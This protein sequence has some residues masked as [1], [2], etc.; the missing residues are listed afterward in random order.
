M[1]ID[2]DVIVI[3]AGGGGPV[4]AKELGELGIDVL[5]LEAG[6]WYGNKKWPE[7][8]KNR[9]EAKESSN[10]NDLDGALYRKQL[11]RLEDDMNDLVTGKFRWG[12]ADRRRT[13]WYRNIPDPALLWQSA[14]IGGST[15]HYYANS[16]RAFPH[17]IDNEWPIR[18]KELVPYYEKVEKTLPVE[19]APTTSKEALFYYGAEKAGFSLN[20]TLDATSPGY[21]PQPNAILPPNEH[22][23]DP[24]YSLEELS[25]M[26]G[27]T[28]SGHCGQ[29][30]P[31]GP[32]LEK[33]AKRSTNVSYVPLAMKTGNV[34]FRPNTFVTKVVTEHG[35]KRGQ[36]AA[37]VQIR[38]T[39][40]GE[41]EELRAKVIVMAAGCIETPRLWLN[42]VLPHND[43]VGRG[44]TTHYM[45]TVTGTFDE[46]TLMEILGSPSVNPFVGHT[47]GARLDYPGLGMIENLGESPGL[48]AMQLFGFSQYGY[49]SLRGSDSSLWEQRGRLVGSELEEAMDGYRKSLT[50]LI[51]TD[52][53][54]D[55]QNRV[56]LDSNIK[57]EHGPVPF[58]HYTP[59]E[60]SIKRREELVK[61]ATN[62][63]RQSGANE[64][65]RSDLPPNY[66]IHIHST[67][68]MGFVVDSSCEAYQVEGLYIA[69]NS[70]DYN[71]LGGPNPTL[72]T[73]ALATRTAEHLANKYF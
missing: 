71:G 2:S 20:K 11:T 18:Y 21:R 61:V 57:D 33:M 65:H 48:S 24:A 26:E 32:T 51:V 10:P 40:T 12:S 45:D 37:G 50:L 27:C 38:D 30:C 55:Y 31:Y 15:I 41:T 56:E 6:P 43:W 64:I 8:N 44:M 36:R 5:V 1:Q 4:I 49:N 59:T 46:Q 14:G 7:P 66:Y 63:L 19:F 52:D 60:K 70:A 34:T 28:L 35:D 62:M 67:M 54:V 9:G 22:L 72:T 42:S 47:S 16:L 13:P 29:G 25:H 68:R 53:E 3:G 69:D 58:V 73:Q 39:W 17:A 23:M